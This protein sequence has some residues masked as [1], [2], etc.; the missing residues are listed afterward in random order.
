MVTVGIDPHKHV[1]VAVAVNADGKRIGKPLTVS[2]DVSLIAV[3]LKWI[4]SIEDGVPVTWAIEDGRGFA[5]RLGVSCQP[6][7][8][9]VAHDRL[10]G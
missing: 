10:A 8:S 6:C 1:H 2:N 3:L 4:R 5:R 7:K 9:E